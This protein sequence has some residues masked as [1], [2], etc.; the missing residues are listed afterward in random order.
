MDLRGGRTA[1]EQ[2]PPAKRPRTSGSGTGK[3]KVK[4]KKQLAEGS[5]GTVF[6]AYDYHT[7]QLHAL[8][9]IKVQ[10]GNVDMLAAARSEISFMHT[11]PPHR[12]ITRYVASSTHE[13]PGG[14]DITF[15][16]LMEY[17]GGVRLS[18]EKRK[19]PSE[20]EVVTIMTHVLDAVDHMHSLKPPV[21]HR[22]IKLD[23]VL[24]D[25]HGT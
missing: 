11:I 22:D 18:D 3:R 5:F 25:G 12:N 9:Q 16:I 10:R 14:R 13:D 6:L 2:P 19:R 23:N 4:V 7:S 24:D 21:A 1:A 17:C 8:K 20:R 15:Y